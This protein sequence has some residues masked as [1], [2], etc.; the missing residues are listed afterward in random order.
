MFTLLATHVLVLMLATWALVRRIRRAQQ[1]D[2]TGRLVSVLQRTSTGAMSVQADGIVD[3]CNPA[4]AQISGLAL[5]G[6]PVTK[7]LAHLEKSPA[8]DGVYAALE[9]HAP[10][11]ASLRW[12]RPDDGEQLRLL[13]EVQPLSRNGKP[14]GAVL[15][16]DDHT[17]EFEM[18]EEIDRARLQMHT[19]EF[20]MH[21]EV[22]RARLQMDAFVQHA[23]APMAMLDRDLRYIACSRRWLS[24]FE[25][26]ETIIGRSQREVMP[27]L[28]EEWHEVYAKCLEGGIV[29]RDAVLFRS[30]AGDERYLRWEVRPWEELDGR[31]GGVLLLA[32][33]VT[34]QVQQNALLRERMDQLDEARRRAESADRAKSEFLAT[35]SHEIRTPMNGI[36]GFAN[37]LLQ[38]RLDAEQHGFASMIHSSAEA[39][40]TIINDILDF[41]KI[42]SGK[43]MLE[44][45]AWNVRETLGDVVDLLAPR[46][47]E[48][49]LSL[50]IDVSERVPE[51]VRGDPGRVRQVVLNLVG[52]ALKFTEKGH[53]ALRVDWADER[54]RVRVEDTGMGVPEQ[55]RPHIFTRFRQADGSTTRRFG[56][57]GLGLSISR[58]L[59]E[60][61]GGVIALEQSS[62]QGS[63]FT[64][65]VP[66]GAEVQE[67]PA[68]RALEG[69]RVL[70][71]EPELAV[72]EVLTRQLWSWGV[73]VEA[74]HSFR[75]AQDALAAGTRFEAL[76]VAEPAEAQQRLLFFGMLAAAAPA[77][78][79]TVLLASTAIRDGVALPGVVTTLV[80]P[81]SRMGPLLEALRSVRLAPVTQLRDGGTAGARAPW[82]GPARVLLV[83]D[84]VVNQRLAQ[85]LLQ[86]LG[87]TVTCAN[88]GLEALQTLEQHTFDFVFMDCHM[89]QLD[90][91]ETTRC[92]RKRWSADVL[93][94]VAL[95]ADAMTGQ[96]ER[97]L[98][99][100]MNDFLTKPLRQLELVSAL[101]RHLRVP[102]VAA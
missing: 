68:A 76:L 87:C 22:E 95:T 84:N 100:G 34:V 18:Y 82:V 42:E 9:K 35:M 65:S 24:D 47:R 51:K 15:V 28:N 14:N 88:N 56:G 50:V 57:T 19:R 94:V 60:R 20:E 25:L 81:L 63:T 73:H 77:P 31:I 70:L 32:V 36:T 26:P 38:S 64:F 61:M 102:G 21:D 67:A 49:R 66:A 46:A 12:Q 80:K 17:R 39:L 3:W 93:P 30:P 54:L 16:V 44:D 48:Q 85:H 4:L 96:R 101:R 74:T 97:C 6:A 10:V 62:S 55:L 92:I 79:P 71:L 23:P 98:A 86:R 59:V 33:D 83:E 91:Y 1:D 11:R 8:T 89:P 72:R 75:A 41:S 58:G 7:F 99:A 5:V 69:M 13:V 45:I 2:R 78:V 29:R 40:L 52:N 37:L 27:A 43:L 90:G 53:V